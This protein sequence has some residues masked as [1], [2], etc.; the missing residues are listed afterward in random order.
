M[1]LLQL[2]LTQGDRTEL[3]GLRRILKSR[4]VEEFRLQ[5]HEV[6][7]VKVTEGTVFLHQSSI[8]MFDNDG[9]FMGKIGTQ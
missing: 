9:A 3:E 8:V 4:G 1:N 2:L 6:A 5:A 7:S